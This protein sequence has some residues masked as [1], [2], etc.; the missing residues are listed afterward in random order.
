MLLTQLVL[1]LFD[2]SSLNSIRIAELWRCRII[3]SRD[4]WILNLGRLSKLLM[5]GKIF[6][7]WKIVSWLLEQLNSK[8]DYKSSSGKTWSRHINQWR[9]SMKMGW[10][11]RKILLELWFTNVQKE[12]QDTSKIGKM[13]LEGINF[14]WFAKKLKRLWWHLTVI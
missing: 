9:I 7:N 3:S 8:V 11:R 10:W 5:S 14:L 2:K 6:P 4:W 1:K 13:T 12:Y